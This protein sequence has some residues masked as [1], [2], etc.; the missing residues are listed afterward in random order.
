MKKLKFFSDNLFL[1]YANGIEGVIH[2]NY[3]GIIKECQLKKITLEHIKFFKNEASV[4]LI[5]SLKVIF[6]SWFFFFILS[7]PMLV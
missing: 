7:T 2:S 6:E 1:E 5:L 4:I 3:H